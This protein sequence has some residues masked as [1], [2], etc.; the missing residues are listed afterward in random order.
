MILPALSQGTYQVEQ[1]VDIG[2][3]L[4]GKRHKIDCM[5]G[6]G[7]KKIFISLK[8]QQSS[9]TAEQKIPYEVMC[10]AKAVWEHKQKNKNVKAYLV[11]G[12][13]DIKGKNNQSKGWTLRDFYTGGKLNDYLH[14]DYAH[15]V[16]IIKTEEFI[17]LANQKKL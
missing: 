15:R 11:L 8:W 2:E 1:Q 3:R 13:L 5:A 12:G 17:A 6:K 9:G 14:P 16:E 10:L 7:N 4:G